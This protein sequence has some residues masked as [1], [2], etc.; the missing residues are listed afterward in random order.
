[1]STLYIDADL[2]VDETASAEAFLAA[3]ADRLMSKL[4]LADDEAW[5][6]A[7]GSPETSIGEAVGIMLATALAMVQEKERDDYA[8]FGEIVLQ[9]P[10]LTAEPAEATSRW[11]F[12]AAG[13]YTVA[14]GSELV[15]DA[16][17]GTPVAFATVG[18]VTFTGTFVDIPAVAV[19]PGAITNNLIGAARDY[20]PLPHLSSVAL[21]TAS[22]NGTDE[23][24]RDEY[25][26]KVVRKARRMKI[27]PIVTDDY[28]DTA[29]DNPSVGAA[30]AVRLLDLTA[31]TDPPAAAGHV[32]V[33]LRT[34]AGGNT[35]A[36]TKEAVRLSMMGDDRPLAVTVHVGDPT[37]TNFRVATSVRLATGADVSA[38]VE[39][40]KDAIRCEYDP[41][42][43]AIDETVAGRW[44]APRTTAERT[45]NAYDVT[46]IIDDTTGLAKIE[47]VTVN[48]GASVVLAGWAPLPNLVGVAAA[49]TTALA[50]A[51][52]DLTY[53]ADTP[54]TVGNDIRIRYLVAGNNTPLSV[55]VA[56]NDITVNVATSAGGAATSTAAQVRDAINAHA[57]AS[58]L[59][60]AANAAAND[61]TGVVAALAYTNLAGGVDDVT[62]TVL[63]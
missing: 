34:P 45:V 30:M 56:G 18:D 2:M 22:A 46:A 19:E 29:L 16:A 20:E 57:G 24:T 17:D 14:D 50:G 25:L 4:D 5:E 48:G 31:P 8:G 63:P 27:V 55:A 32:S 51:N 6:P 40:I 23:Q 54:G 15:L 12:D 11:T 36:A 13:T 43:Y 26:E 33:F 49:L 53:T 1:M 7:E 9:E 47:D 61:G 41:A 62:V 42:T 3:L 60:T 52:N 21:V 37:R 10:R 38:T 58:A 35:D 44:R 28:A 39:A 59:V